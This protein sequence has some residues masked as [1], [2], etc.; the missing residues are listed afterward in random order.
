MKVGQSRPARL[1]LLSNNSTKDNGMNDEGN[2]PNDS[3]LK[4]TTNL[5][6]APGTIRIELVQSSKWSVALLALLLVCGAILCIAWVAIERS[7]T[8]ILHPES[9]LSVLEL[10]ESVI[11]FDGIDRHFTG[12]QWSDKSKIG[13]SFAGFARLGIDLTKA[14]FDLD[15]LHRRLTI[16]LPEPEVT[17][18]NVEEAHIWER[19]ANS[20]DSHKLDELECKLCNDALTEFK[21]VAEEDF[22]RD[23]A[24]RLAK[25]VL[26][27]Y[28]KR[29]YPWLEVEFKR[30][31]P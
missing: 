27:A 22:Y 2:K 18:V 4:D 12:F 3:V 16:A 31:R 5:Q 9:K 13:I 6:L 28:Y 24:N 15:R 20:S 11:K 17:E 14:E 30:G 25:A 10:E 7:T 26:R 19:R 1:K 21:K 23:A 29:N 8:R